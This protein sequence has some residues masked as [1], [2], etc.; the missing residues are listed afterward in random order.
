[1]CQMLAELKQQ[2]EE[3]IRMCS[4]ARCRHQQHIAEVSWSATYM[5]PA[6]LLM[7]VRCL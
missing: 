7:I 1:M 6:L 4:S 5:N 2:I 3:F